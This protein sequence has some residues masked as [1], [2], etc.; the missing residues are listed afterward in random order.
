MG[1]FLIKLIFMLIASA[2]IIKHEFSRDILCTF[3]IIYLITRTLTIYLFSFK[4][5]FVRT[6]KLYICIVLVNI[7]NI[8]VK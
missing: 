6:V 5:Y 7:R 1:G 3:E 2:A 4:K 8:Y